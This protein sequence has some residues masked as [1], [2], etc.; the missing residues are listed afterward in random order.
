MY[1]PCIKLD[2]EAPWVSQGLRASSLVNDRGEPYDERCLH[3]GRAQEIGACEMCD[4]VSDLEEA[5]GTRASGV[6]HALGDPLPIEL[7]K[8]LDQMVVFE[9]HGSYHILHKPAKI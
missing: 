5:L 9:E 4:V 3:A 1:L 8:L 2:C 6:N 7:R